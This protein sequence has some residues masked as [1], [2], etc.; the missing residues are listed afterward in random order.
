MSTATAQIRC[1]CEPSGINLAHTSLSS[2]RCTSRGAEVVERGIEHHRTPSTAGRQV[3][4]SA[5]SKRGRARSG[6]Q[7]QQASKT[8]LRALHWQQA[9]L[10]VGG[11]A[12]VWLTVSTAA[13]DTST[14][15]KSGL[16]RRTAAD[17]RVRGT[18]TW[19]VS[20][21]AWLPGWWW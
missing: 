11:T 21:A 5:A 8:A 14:R 15:S 16:N 12:G 18:P 13:F 7:I 6:E 19:H 2:G 20:D 3:Y 1:A 17:W 10:Q 4:Q 9:S